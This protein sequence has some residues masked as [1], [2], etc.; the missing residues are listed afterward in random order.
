LSKLANKINLEGILQIVSQKERTQLGNKELCINKFY[1]LLEKAL[2]VAKKRRKT[3]PTRSSVEKR[4]KLKKMI[5]EQKENRKK[6][7]NE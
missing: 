3:R 1:D 2:T 5:S 4:I 6:I 7:E